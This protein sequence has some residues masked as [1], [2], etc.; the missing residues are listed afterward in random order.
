MGERSRGNLYSEKGNFTKAISD[1]RIAEQLFSSSSPSKGLALARIAELEK[2]IAA[3]APVAVAPAPAPQG[4]AAAPSR[5]VALVIGNSAY[6]HVPALNNPVNDAGLIA[7]ALK[8]DGFDVTVADNLDRDSLI[9]TLKAFS[10]RSDNADWAVVYFAGH[11]IEMAGIDYLIPV[12]AKLATDRDVKLESIAADDVMSA[13][14]GA[15]ELRVVILDACRDNPFAA[16]MKRSTG[17]FRDIGRGLARI[18]PDQGS[19]IVYSARPGRIA[20]DGVGA[21]SPF[22][23][24]LANHLTDPGVEVLKLFRLVRDDVLASTG[25]GQEVFQDSSLPGKDFFFRS[26]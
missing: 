2:Q 5:R 21:N 23:A 11:G 26:H 7:N 13:I 24:A 25:N 15:H 10:A 12:D 18:V 16:T 3:A 1:Y 14:D 9:N 20:A 19:V 22:A 17:V 6:Q 4:A 8:T